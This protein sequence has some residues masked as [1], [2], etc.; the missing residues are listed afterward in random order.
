MQTVLVLAI[1]ACKAVTSIAELSF[2]SPGLHIHQT[3]VKDL[4]SEPNQCVAAAT[5]V[6]TS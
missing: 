4:C 3:I 6:L 2:Q 1:M 5:Y